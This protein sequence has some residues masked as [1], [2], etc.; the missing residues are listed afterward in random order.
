M[1]VTS[2]RGGTVK[3]GEPDATSE[4]VRGED[5]QVMG[6]P[7]VDRNAAGTYPGIFIAP[8]ETLHGS[9]VESCVEGRASEYDAPPCACRQAHA[10]VAES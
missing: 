9:D 8:A 3:P 6:I 4:V 7:F 10:A 2:G 5:V 1:T